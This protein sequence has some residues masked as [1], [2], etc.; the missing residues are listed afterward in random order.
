MA[1]I[2]GFENV[3]ALNALNTAQQT[4][5][6]VL[7]PESMSLEE[8]ISL[9]ELLVLKGFW[10][11]YRDVEGRT[12]L[13]SFKKRGLD[14]IDI[15]QCWLRPIIAQ[16]DNMDLVEEKRTGEVILNYD[17]VKKLFY[18]CGG[19]DEQWAILGWTKSPSARSFGYRSQ[20]DMR[21]F[22]LLLEVDLNPLRIIN[23]SDY[24][25]RGLLHNAALISEGSISPGS[26]RQSSNALR[27]DLVKR[28]LDIGDDANRHDNWGITP[29]M[30]H[31]RGYPYHHVITE[32]LLGRGAD[33]NAR[34]SKGKTAL[35]IAVKRGNIDATKSLLARGA[36]VHVRDKKYEGVLMVGAKSQRRA[37]TN[38]LYAR[39]TACMA[40]AIDAGAIARPNMFLEWDATERYAGAD[41]DYPYSGDS[42]FT[43]EMRMMST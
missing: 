16:M 43:A 15:A 20:G 13:D 12:F 33:P 17:F 37:K 8:M 3:S 23:F 38:R 1:L 14:P 41:R 40:L 39:V 5:M 25:G 36:N 27:V 24:A 7:N 34:D 22:R 18:E 11:H 30:A 19:N 6:H 35:H 26:Q 42:L 4:F 9:R 21:I 28:L 2:D 31:L 32:I 10:F 29:L